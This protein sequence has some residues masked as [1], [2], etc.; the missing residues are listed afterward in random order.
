MIHV[1]AVLSFWQP[2][3]H[4]QAECLIYRIPAEAKK[5]AD[6]RNPDPRHYYR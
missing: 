1:L 2:T 4:V 3:I 5:N 6:L